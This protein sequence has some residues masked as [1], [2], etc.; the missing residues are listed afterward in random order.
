MGAC[1][2]S[3]L[4]F[5]SDRSRSGLAE[6]LVFLKS[7]AVNKNRLF[8]PF[9]SSVGIP[10][11]VSPAPTGKGGGISERHGRN[12]RLT[13]RRGRRRSSASVSSS[14]WKRGRNIGTPWPQYEVDG[15][16]RA[17]AGRRGRWRTA[18]ICRA[19]P[20]PSVAVAAATT[21]GEGGR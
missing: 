6:N 12:T 14:N 1:R 15:T 18:T 19:R 21:A 13:G 4:V 8:L 3:F 16:A 20:P 11:Q 17:A 5:V 9:L 7:C 10:P 2:N